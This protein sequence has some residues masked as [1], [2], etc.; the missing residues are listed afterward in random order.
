MTKKKAISKKTISK[1]KI[2]SPSKIGKTHIAIILDRSGSME[3]IRGETIAHFN[4]QI[5]T[6][7]KES[8][9]LDTS[10][11]LVTFSSTVEIVFANKSINEVK[12]LTLKTYTPNGGTALYDAVGIAING[13]SDLQD[14]NKKDTAVLVIILSDGGENASRTFTQAHIAEKIQTL[15][16]TKRWTFTY[17]G[18]NQDLA[19]IQEQLNIPK[20]NIQSFVA[21]AGGMLKATNMA[22]SS[23]Q[24]YYANRRIGETQSVGYYVEQGGTGGNEIKIK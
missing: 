4:E 7:T 3:S 9:G 14:I 20:G 21:D 11:S 24:A 13:L 5:E 23:S 1:K 10:V 16:D 12:P 19:K 15:Q 6:V 22:N 17:L 8:A 2:V 18:A